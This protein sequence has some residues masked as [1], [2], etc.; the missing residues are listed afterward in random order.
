MP[1][2]Y[3]RVF[4]LILTCPKRFAW[5]L[6]RA[7][8]KVRNDGDGKKCL[9]GAGAKVLQCIKKLC[10]HLQVSIIGKILIYSINIEKT[11]S[12]YENASSAVDRMT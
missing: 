7:T 10:L 3:S 12:F 2:N 11:F 4:D 5:S 8:R 1:T 6:Q 9:E